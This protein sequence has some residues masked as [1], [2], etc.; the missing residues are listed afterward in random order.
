MH[1]LPCYCC[2]LHKVHV[3]PA[4]PLYLRCDSNPGSACCLFCGLLLNTLG[5]DV[6][7]HRHE[8]VQIK[9][10]G[11]SEFEASHVVMEGSHTF[12]VGPSCT[13]ACHARLFVLQT[14]FATWSRCTVLAKSSVNRSHCNGASGSAGLSLLG[15]LRDLVTGFSLTYAIQHAGL[16]CVFRQ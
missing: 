2:C 3:G 12:E 9:L 1:C 13:P 5:V 4:V 14:S 11:Q 7:V 15:M 10:H 16:G 8:S 6:Q